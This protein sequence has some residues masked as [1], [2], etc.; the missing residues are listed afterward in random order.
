MYPIF[1]K[2]K[3]RFIQFSK[4]DYFYSLKKEYLHY[5]CFIVDFYKILITTVTYF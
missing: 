5:K 4:L 2:K 1:D 3:E